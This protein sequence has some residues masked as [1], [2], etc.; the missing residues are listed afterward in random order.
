[1]HPLFVYPCFFIGEAS[2][3]AVGLCSSHIKVGSRLG[4]I[5]ENLNAYFYPKT[6]RYTQ[7]L[8]LDKKQQAS[9]GNSFGST[10]RFGPSMPWVEP[11]DNLLF[12]HIAEKLFFTEIFLVCVACPLSK[13]G[14]PQV[15]RHSAVIIIAPGWLRCWNWC[16]LL[17]FTQGSW[18]NDTLVGYILVILRYLSPAFCIN[19]AFIIIITW[20]PAPC[21]IRSRNTY[22]YTKTYRD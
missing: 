3:S 1:M 15:F 12:D 7:V 4:Y 9:R 22:V 6:L 21:Y 20:L 10:K 13:R 8:S 5:L 17:I 19:L 16:S 11:Y 14:Q 18:A 2:G